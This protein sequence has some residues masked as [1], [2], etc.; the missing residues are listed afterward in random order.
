MALARRLRDLAAD[1]ANF[2][3]LG[4]VVTQVNARL[5]LRFHKLQKGKRKLN[6][7]VSG[8]VTIGAAPA[9]IT[10]YEGPTGA[11]K[12]NGPVATLATEPM[13]HPPPSFR[14][15]LDPVGRVTR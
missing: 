1:P 12:V 8:V 5:F 6:K 15:P 2:A 4:E 3:A 10:V 14:N 7:L 13:Y 9:P 11:K